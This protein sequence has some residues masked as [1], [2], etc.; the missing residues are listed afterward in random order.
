MIIKFLFFLLI[1][2]SIAASLGD[3]NTGITS[4]AMERP[5]IRFRSL[6]PPSFIPRKGFTV[7]DFINFGM[8]RI[9]DVKET[10]VECGES[11]EEVGFESEKSEINGKETPVE[12]SK[13]V[14]L[15]VSF[16]PAPSRKGAEKSEVATENDQISGK[17]KARISESDK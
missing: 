15:K 5:V 3:N 6:I 16:Q 11:D 1:A 14:T 7:E 2:T 17:K 13:T 12:E 9:E 4:L 8:I 10:K